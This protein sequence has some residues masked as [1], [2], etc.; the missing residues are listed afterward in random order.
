M[1]LYH[2]HRN[3]SLLIDQLESPL[4]ELLLKS[5]NKLAHQAWVG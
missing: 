1:R 4:P 3:F 2:W 5:Q